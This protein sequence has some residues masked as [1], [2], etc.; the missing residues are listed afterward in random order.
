M[1]YNYNIKRVLLLFS[2]FHLLTY[3]NITIAMLLTSFGRFWS[4]NF[5]GE[6]SFEVS[7][8]EPQEAKPD[9]DLV[10]YY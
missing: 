8:M 6:E 10:I 7:N 9:V 5:V 2:Y 4:K 3:E 1:Y